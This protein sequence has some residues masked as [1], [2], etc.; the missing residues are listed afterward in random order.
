MPIFPITAGDSRFGSFNLSPARFLKTSRNFRFYRNNHTKIFKMKYN[1]SKFY[2]WTFKCRPRGLRIKPN[3][4]I[5]NQVKSLL[6]KKAKHGKK[7]GRQFRVSSV[8]EKYIAWNSTIRGVI[9]SSSFRNL[10]KVKVLLYVMCVEAI[11]VL[12]MEVKMILIDTRTLKTISDMWITDKDIWMQHN[13]KEFWN[14]RYWCKVNGCKIR[15][16][17]SKSWAAFFWFFG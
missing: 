2:T 12:Q 16:K 3:F 10:A 8:K 11:S 17:S 9:N 4:P 15:P 13:N 14:N 7:D 5:I 6:W 1:W